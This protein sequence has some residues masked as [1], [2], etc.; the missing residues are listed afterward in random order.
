MVWMVPLAADASPE[1]QAFK[2]FGTYGSDLWHGENSA[3]YDLE[4][5]CSDGTDVNMTYWED[6]GAGV[7]TKVT[8]VTMSIHVEDVDGVAIQG[9]HVCI[10]LDPETAYTSGTGNTARDLDLVVY[11]TVDDEVPGVG[12]LRVLDVSE[13]G[14]QWYRFASWDTKTFTFPTAISYACTGGGTSTL[15]QDSVNNFTTMD[16]EEGDTVRNHTDGSWANVETITD[17]SNITTTEL[18]GGSDNTW[19][20]GDTYEFHKLATTLVSQIDQISIPLMNDQT[21][22]SGDV[23]KG[24]KYQASDQDVTIRV[25]HAGYQTVDTVGTITNPDGM[26]VTVVMPDDDVY[27]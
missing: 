15:L 23:S 2:F 21:D 14:V 13:N 9:A 10:H 24:F 16:I 8:S 26:T 22:A 27:V 3:N 4:L 12:W 11:E 19:T 18:T 20:S 7:T 17:A 1:M 5:Q 6:S 25:R